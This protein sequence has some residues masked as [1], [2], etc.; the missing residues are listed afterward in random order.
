MVRPDE[1]C[2][3]NRQ[4]TAPSLYTQVLS[5][6]FMFFLCSSA[7]CLGYFYFLY[8]KF[9]PVSVDFTHE[10]PEAAIWISFWLV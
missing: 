3:L 9:I 5:P 8:P 10:R 2:R 1:I 6:V 7:A 4:R